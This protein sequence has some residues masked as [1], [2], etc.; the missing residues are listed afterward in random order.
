MWGF[1]TFSEPKLIN[2]RTISFNNFSL[3][4]LFV[5]DQFDFQL[6][7]IGVVRCFFLNTLKSG[8]DT[9]TTHRWTS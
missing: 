2:L 6:L 7:Q 9:D 3:I 4:I 5:I 8:T 1:L